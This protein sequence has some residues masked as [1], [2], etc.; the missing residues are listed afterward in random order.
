MDSKP[1]VT[2]SKSM[3]NEPWFV[4][5]PERRNINIRSRNQTPVLKSWVDQPL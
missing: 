3:D 2:Y 1:S 4:P 5:P